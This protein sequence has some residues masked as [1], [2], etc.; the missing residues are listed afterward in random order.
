[1]YSKDDQ[2][3]QSSKMEPYATK[4]EP[5]PED[6]TIRSE[7][8]GT[9]NEN[10]NDRTSK[11]IPRT[12]TPLKL[13]IPGAKPW[14]TTETKVGANTNHAVVTPSRYAPEVINTDLPEVV[15]ITP[16][17][18]APE[19]R[20]VDH[21]SEKITVQGDKRLG[22]SPPSHAKGKIPPTEAK[23]VVSQSQQR[24]KWYLRKGN[25]VLLAAILLLL[26]CIIAIATWIGVKRARNGLA[27]GI[28]STKA[29]GMAA[30]QWLDLEGIKHYRVYFQT[31]QNTILESAWDSN[32]SDWDVSTVAS[33]DLKTQN[34]SSLGAAAGW[35][36][37]NYSQVHVSQVSTFCQII[38]SLGL[39]NLFRG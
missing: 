3:N 37:A 33:A 38:L 12:K 20:I 39:R 27:G 24:R 23:Q 31:Q 19:V 2:P 14:T 22:E 29:S 11:Q 16:S 1:V 8:L 25:R 15:P 32:R 30:M 34:Q 17:A 6:H 13:E 5:R 21:L 28:S 18:T 10:P 35:P 9:N 26:I 36:H 7:T 4:D